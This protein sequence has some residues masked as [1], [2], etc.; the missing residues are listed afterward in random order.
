M[1]ERKTSFVALLRKQ[2][3]PLRLPTQ[4]LVL[5]PQPFQLPLK[6]DES[7]A[8]QIWKLQLKGWWPQLLT[9]Q[10]WTGKPPHPLG[11][12]SLWPSQDLLSKRC[13][14]LRQLVAT[15]RLQARR[16]LPLLAIWPLKKKCE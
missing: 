3:S 14:L 13:W 2:T 1:A 8:C 10:R 15:K 4:F 12:R 9:L 7:L 16:L 11:Q 6:T 5:L